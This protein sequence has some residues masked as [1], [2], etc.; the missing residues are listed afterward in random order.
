MYT[1]AEIQPKENKLKK[2]EGRVRKQT[3][4]GITPVFTEVRVSQTELIMYFFRKR[5]NASYDENFIKCLT[6]VTNRAVS[7]NKEVKV[8]TWLEKIHVLR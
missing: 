8:K 2:K 3:E 7:E 4:I 6:S 1:S 5:G